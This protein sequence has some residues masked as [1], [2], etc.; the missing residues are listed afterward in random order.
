MAFYCSYD[1]SLSQ[2]PKFGWFDM[3]YMVCPMPTSPLCSFISSWFWLYHH[4][5]LCIWLLPCLKCSLHFVFWLPGIHQ[6]LH[7]IF[8]LE[9]SYTFFSQPSQ[10]V[11]VHFTLSCH[12]GPSCLTDLGQFPL[13]HALRILFLCFRILNL[14]VFLHS[15]MELIKV[16]LHLTPGSITA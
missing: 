1:R 13:P 6:S 11:N 4:T 3:L 14:A 8:Y 9:D 16:C 12:L 5:V 2:T 7:L 15:Q 10:Q